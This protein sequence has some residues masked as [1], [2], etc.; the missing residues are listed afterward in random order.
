MSQDIQQYRQ[1]DTTPVGH[2]GTRV[3]IQ[4]RPACPGVVRR[5]DR[6]RRGDRELAGHRAARPYQGRAVLWE[7]RRHCPSYEPVVDRA[8]DQPTGARDCAVLLLL[9]RW[10]CVRSR[11]RDCDSTISIGAAGR[12]LSTARL[13][14]VISWRS[15]RCRRDDRGSSRR[16]WS[17]RSRC[18]QYS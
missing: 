1:P 6:A 18:S 3:V 14:A 11:S 8:A 4:E 15:P 9:A 16:R 12:S 7:L 17:S 13:I 2:S 10:D 5:A